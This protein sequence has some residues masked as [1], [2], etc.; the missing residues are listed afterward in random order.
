FLRILAVRGDRSRNVPPGAKPT[1]IVLELPEEFGPGGLQRPLVRLAGT[2]R[3]A[4]GDLERLKVLEGP[5]DGAGREPGGP[6]DVRGRKLLAVLDRG[7]GE[8][9]DHAV[10]K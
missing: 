9:G 10:A 5:A 8:G 1:R 4:P 7:L 3:V 6:G 2:G